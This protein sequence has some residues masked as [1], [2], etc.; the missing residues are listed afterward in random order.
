MQISFGHNH[1]SPLSIVALACVSGSLLFVFGCILQACFS[2]FRQ[3]KEDTASKL[4]GS[5]AK[6]DAL[7]K[8]AKAAK[9]KLAAACQAEGTELVA[10]LREGEQVQH[11]LSACI[12]DY[13]TVLEAETSD[14]VFF[15]VVNLPQWPCAR[16]TAWMSRNKVTVKV[17]TSCRDSHD[18]V[19]TPGQLPDVTRSPT[20]SSIHIPLKPD[21]SAALLLSVH[22]HRCT[23]SQSHRR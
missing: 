12:A 6:I 21:E 15:K 9:E 18:L 14:D 4:A 10:A 13:R 7:V 19:P 20:N 5:T 22:H 8:H 3:P 16:F 11:D 1:I 23:C 17:R 2:C